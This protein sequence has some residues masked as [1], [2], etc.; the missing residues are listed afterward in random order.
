ENLKYKSIVSIFS[1]KFIL[2]FIKKY[3]IKCDKKSK[4]E[5]FN[6]DYSKFEELIIAIKFFENYLEKD[7]TKE[8]LKLKIEE[9]F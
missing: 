2:S 7:I 1:D 5:L 6:F 9:L 4:I 8:H 3:K